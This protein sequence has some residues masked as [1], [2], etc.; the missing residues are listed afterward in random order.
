MHPAPVRIVNQSSKSCYIRAPCT[1]PSSRRSGF[2]REWLKPGSGLVALAHPCAP[3][4]KY[5][6]YVKPLL[7]DAHQTA[8]LLIELRNLQLKLRDLL[9]RPCDH[10]GRGI[11]QKIRI[12]ELG[13]HSP[14]IGI[15]ALAL[16][17]KT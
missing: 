14:E 5:I 12:I 1:A 15:D 6:L 10:F 9:P 2:S 11:V 8:K 3:R 16:L 13:A 4:H 7:R 17:A